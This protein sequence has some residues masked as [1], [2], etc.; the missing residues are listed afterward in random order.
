ML[1]DSDEDSEDFFIAAQSAEDKETACS[2]ENCEES[3]V[4][5]PPQD[6][7]EEQVVSRLARLW[8]QH[9]SEQGGG[10]PDLSDR[11]AASAEYRRWVKEVDVAL[12]SGGEV[13]SFT[14]LW[15]ELNKRP[16]VQGRSRSPRSSSDPR[17]R[18]DGWSQGR[19][20]RWHSAQEALQLLLDSLSQFEAS[21]SGRSITGQE[22]SASMRKHSREFSIQKTPFEKLG[23]LLQLA[24]QDGWIRLTWT[25]DSMSVQILDLPTNGVANLA[26]AWEHEKDVGI[27]LEPARPPILR[28]VRRVDRVQHVA[29]K[30]APYAAPLADIGGF[31]HLRQRA[32]ARLSASERGKLR[33]VTPERRSIELRAREVKH[34]NGVL[35]RRD[36]HR[37]DRERPSA[38]NRRRSR[39]RHRE[40]SLHRF[41]GRNDPRPRS[42][43]GAGR[44]P[45]HPR[46][47]SCSRE[48]ARD[49]AVLGMAK[50][51]RRTRCEP[52]SKKKASKAAASKAASKAA[53]KKKDHTKV[54]SSEQDAERKVPP[55]KRGREEEAPKH[56]AKQVKRS[57]AEDAIPL[58]AGKAK[59][60]ARKSVADA[61]K[62]ESSEYEYYSYYSE[63]EEDKSE[64]SSSSDSD[65]ASNE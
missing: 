28:E 14:E 39:S 52:S 59:S 56:E 41:R 21:A 23:K 29:L 57:K 30:P 18:F 20:S 37:P 22:L 51:V 63:Q 32:V 25:G 54:R 31:P 61:P 35:T 5:E 7:P 42:R 47:V 43:D 26:N 60:K 15:I 24:A 34:P 3:V 16:A 2:E 58:I 8:R 45:R 46:E 53:A 62:K 33:S 64:S 38:F 19:R 65:D 44:R 10:G 6:D 4:A 49:T 27:R 9:V 1:S 12:G 13:P 48:H 36:E 55:H 17:A 11:L 50:D 40:V